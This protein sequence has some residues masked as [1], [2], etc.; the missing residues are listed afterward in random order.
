M[1]LSIDSGVR[2]G[3]LTKRFSETQ[4]RC[5]FGFVPVSKV[6]KRFILLL[7]SPQRKLMTVKVNSVQPSCIYLRKRRNRTQENGLKQK[8]IAGAMTPKLYQC[9]S[10]KQWTRLMVLFINSCVRCGGLTKCF[11]KHRY[12]LSLVS[13]QLAM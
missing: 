2:C 4:I 3:G 13:S 6:V 9:V 5:Q 11:L 1:V 8:M 12:N 7:F 10:L